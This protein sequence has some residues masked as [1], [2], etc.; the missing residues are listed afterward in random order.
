MDIQKAN[1]IKKE[2]HRIPD[3]PRAPRGDKT[4]S[5]IMRN[6]LDEFDGTQIMSLDYA[7]LKS[8]KGKGNG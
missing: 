4:T 6:F 7:W 1:R 8:P 3:N 2:D 5:I